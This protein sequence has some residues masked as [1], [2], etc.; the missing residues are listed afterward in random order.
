MFSYRLKIINHDPVKKIIK[1][2]NI[3]EI[4]HESLPEKVHVTFLSEA[5]QVLYYKIK[6]TGQTLLLHLG[7]EPVTPRSKD[8]LLR[9]SYDFFKK[10][11]KYLKL[12]VENIF[13]QIS[14]KQKNAYPF[15]FS[16]FP[17]GYK[18]YVPDLQLPEIL[19][20]LA[21]IIAKN[22]V[23]IRLDNKTILLNPET[24]EIKL[25]QVKKLPSQ[26]E[27]NLFDAIF[28]D[29]ISSIKEPNKKTLEALMRGSKRGLENQKWS[30][31]TLEK[32]MHSLETESF[33]YPLKESLHALVDGE[34]FENLM[35]DDDFFIDQEI[36]KDEETDKKTQAKEMVD[37]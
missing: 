9:Q 12:H 3:Q 25:L 13:H 34:I 35:S 7:L 23:S 1:N 22:K 8:S 17:K 6:T 37:Q 11:P 19:E 20:T 30:D 21:E 32:V 4:V 29:F 24:K 10:N 18:S 16:E 27:K 5:E 14:L 36:L 31:Q 28:V 2:K 15:F 26:D 33:S